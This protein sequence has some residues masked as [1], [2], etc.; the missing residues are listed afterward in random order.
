LLAPPPEFLV[1]ERRSGPGVPGG[2]EWVEVTQG[3]PGL[4]ANLKEA[5][6]ALQAGPR[7]GINDRLCV[8]DIAHANNSGISRALVTGASVKLSSRPSCGKV[9][10]R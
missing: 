10:R 6:E 3:P 2:A 8:V 4:V 5:V 9:R 1:G 7:G